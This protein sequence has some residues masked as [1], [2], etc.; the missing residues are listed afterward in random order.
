[1]NTHKI[2]LVEDDAEISEMLAN[3]LSMENY[4]VACVADGQEACNQFD[5]GTFS[6]AELFNTSRSTIQY[7]RT[8]LNGSSARYMSISTWT[9]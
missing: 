7:R 5:S 1:M 9:N 4:E 3:Y 8:T 6:I 2:L